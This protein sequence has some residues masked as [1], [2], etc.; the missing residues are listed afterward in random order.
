MN[1]V[2]FGRLVLVCG[3]SSLAMNATSTVRL[4]AISAKP[5][6]NPVATLTGCLS[7]SLTKTEMF[8]APSAA[9]DGRSDPRQGHR[10]QIGAGLLPS[11]TI[12]A[13]AGAIDPVRVAEAAAGGR[14][15]R[16]R[17][18]P[19]DIRLEL[20]DSPAVPQMGRCQ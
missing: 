13:Q 12:A 2:T 9:H 16:D 10:I 8:R 15:G 19:P 17:M 6:L 20:G 14:A 18:Q 5:T 4:M 1:V 3:V 11:A 7:P